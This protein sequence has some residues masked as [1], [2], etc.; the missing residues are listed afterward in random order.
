MVWKVGAAPH[1]DGGP[2]RPTV[3]LIL[4]LPH[5]GAVTL[6]KG[7]LRSRLRSVL[8]KWPSLSPWLPASCPRLAQPVLFVP[9]PTV[10]PLLFQWPL[11][12]DP[13]QTPAGSLALLLSPQHRLW[14]A[15]LP[16]GTDAG[17]GVGTGHQEELPGSKGSVGEAGPQRGSGAHATVLGSPRGAVGD[18]SCSDPGWELGGR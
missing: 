1:T 9:L 2:E 3:G 17:Q 11:P 6:N 14:E 10:T 8:R 7:S 15:S 18:Q 13:T 16:G 4:L 12:C 5:G